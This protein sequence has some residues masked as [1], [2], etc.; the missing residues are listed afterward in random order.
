M[1]GAFSARRPAQ[2]LAA[3]CRRRLQTPPSARPVVWP[4]RGPDVAR[5]SPTETAI[6]AHSRFDL[7]APRG[8]I[9]GAYAYPAH[10]HPRR[11]IR[12][13]SAV[14]RHVPAGAALA[15]ATAWRLP[16]HGAADADRLPARPG[17]WAS[18]RGPRK[19]RGRAPP[20]AAARVAG[21][22]ADVPAL[23]ARA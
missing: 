17:G 19:R 21:V 8:A 15:R 5:G 7:I 14:A 4:P 2:P 1:P 10:T 11:A 22:R 16:V 13:W 23:R 12:V 9:A 6:R 18:S 3:T 20:P